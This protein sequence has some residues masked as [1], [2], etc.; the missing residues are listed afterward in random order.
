MKFL[1]LIFSIMTSIVAIA[2]TITIVDCREPIYRLHETCG[3]NP[4]SPW[5]CV[6]GSEQEIVGSAELFLHFNMK[7][8]KGSGYIR[9]QFND[10]NEETYHDIECGP[11]ENPYQDSYECTSIG[12]PKGSR[13]VIST[14]NPIYKEFGFSIFDEKR[15]GSN[16]SV[17]FAVSKCPSAW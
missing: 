8:K 14:G 2:E 1:I 4:E 5:S 9:I 15:Y 7:T 12:F 16:D 11:Y 6:P 13:R 10:E 3:F 17:H